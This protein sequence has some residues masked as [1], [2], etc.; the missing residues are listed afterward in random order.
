MSCSNHLK[1]MGLA[2]HNYESVFKRLPSLGSQ[3]SDTFSIQAQLLPYVEQAGLQDLINFAEPFTDPAFTG[4]SFRA[5][6]NPKH[7]RAAE[8]IVPTFLCPSDSSDVTYSKGGTQWKGHNY[9]GNLG[10]GQELAYDAVARRT[11]GLFFYG[12]TKN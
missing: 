3:T 11:D 9:M 1:Q 12:P 5:P 4:P 2:L 10:S 8:T 6:I 7:Q